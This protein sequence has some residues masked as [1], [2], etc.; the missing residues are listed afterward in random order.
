MLALAAFAVAAIG[1]TGASGATGQLGR[2]QTIAGGTY[3]GSGSN[4]VP[5]ALSST[6][7]RYILEMSAKPV[8]VVDAAHKAAGHGKLNFAQRAALTRSIR[9]QQAPVVAAVQRLSGARVY[10]RFQGVYNGIAVVLPQRD[11]WKLGNISGVKA[12]FAA[13]QST[14]N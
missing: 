2:F 3:S 5:F 12:I 10:E 13:H 6:P 9:G 11:A 1:L 14:H 4:F 8:A 7:A